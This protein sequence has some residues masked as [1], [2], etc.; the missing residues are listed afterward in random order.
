MDSAKKVLDT[1]LYWITVVLFA[2]LVVIVVWQ[3][4]TRQVLGD[5]STWT[6]EGARLTFVWL[7]LFAAAFVFGERGH[8]A[9]E[10]VARKFPARV[11]T[12]LA[13]AV[14]LVVLLFAVVVLV[15]GGWRAAENAWLQN[16]SALPFTLGQMYLALPVSGVLIAFYSVYYVVGIARGTKAPYLELEGDPLAV[17][18]QI[19]ADRLATDPPLV[20]SADTPDSPGDHPT[21]PKTEA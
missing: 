13:V 5:P 8:I 1:V 4:V 19:Q 3:I 11:E 12:V 7:G 17:D 6:E 18:P 2:L 10:F 16:L 21:G 9:V 14:Q 20:T 15:W